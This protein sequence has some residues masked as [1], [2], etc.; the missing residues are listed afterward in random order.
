MSFGARPLSPEKASS[1]ISQ[2]SQGLH[3]TMGFLY[4]VPTF[5]ALPSCPGRLT[6]QPQGKGHLPGQAHA[7]TT[8]MRMGAEAS[9]PLLWAGW[10]DGGE[11]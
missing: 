6:P 5:P 10:E 9:L 11:G 8:G 7:D 4:P 2:R 3:E 1:S